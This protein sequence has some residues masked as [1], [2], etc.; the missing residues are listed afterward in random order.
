MTHPSALSVA[1]SARRWSTRRLLPFLWLLYVIALLD[2]ANV[3]YAAPERSHDLA[4]SDRVFGLGAGIFSI[5]NVLLEIP[6]AVIVERWSAR[7]WITR[8][9]ISQEI[10]TVF[11]VLVT[12]RSG[13]TWRGFY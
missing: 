2:R 1:Q 8:V 3:A 12:L 13:F 6:G 9:T 4:F 7:R 10:I 11:V 5:G